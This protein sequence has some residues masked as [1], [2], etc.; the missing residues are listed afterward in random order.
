MAVLVATARP[1]DDHPKD[2]TLPS[3]GSAGGYGATSGRP[4]QE[5]AGGLHTSARGSVTSLRRVAWETRPPNWRETGPKD[6]RAPTQ[7]P[8][9]RP[10]LKTGAHLGRAGGRFQSRCAKFWAFDLD[11]ERTRR[12]DSLSPSAQNVARVAGDCVAL[13]PLGALAKTLTEPEV[14]VRQLHPHWSSVFKRFG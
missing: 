9:R 1:A 13:F 8:K 11:S 10:D 7:V 5:L 12:C 3:E 4:S 14:D 2:G 6:R